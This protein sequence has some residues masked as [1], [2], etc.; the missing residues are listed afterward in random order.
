MIFLPANQSHMLK[1][2]EYHYLCNRHNFPNPASP[3]IIFSHYNFYKYQTKFLDNFLATALV[4]ESRT[5]NS[6]EANAK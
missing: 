3:Q 1:I 6:Q 4:F 2:L 5:T